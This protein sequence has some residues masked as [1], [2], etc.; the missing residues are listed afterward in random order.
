MS[1][2]L[3][4]EHFGPP[5]YQQY[6]MERQLLNNLQRGVYENVT[7]HGA[8]Q[9]TFQPPSPTERVPISFTHDSP[10]ARVNHH[11]HHQGFY[12][13]LNNPPTSSS[14]I[15]VNPLSGQLNP[16]P[17]N[18][19]SSSAPLTS[20]YNLPSPLTP[21]SLPLSATPATP[22]ADSP[23]YSSASFLHHNPLLNNPPLCSN[24]TLTNNAPGIVN[25]A[26]IDPNSLGRAQVAGTRETTS[27]LNRDRAHV[28][29]EIV[30]PEELQ[31]DIVS[32]AVISPLD[33]AQNSSLPSNTDST[34]RPP[35]PPRVTRTPSRSPPAIPENI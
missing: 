12:A 28:Y 31:T 30:V 10:Y 35:L 11:H 13:P 14:N 34:E 26:P 27:S 2:P 3:T 7:P 4:S 19:A 23:V 21:S 5:P 33:T 6:F 32:Q 29:D 22:A 24:V 15:P 9:S 16:A 1:G 17:L 8:M 25:S 20:L 18:P